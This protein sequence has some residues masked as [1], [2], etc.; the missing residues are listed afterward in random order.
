MYGV[1][2]RDVR[3]QQLNQ[4]L[5]QFTQADNI[6]NVSEKYYTIVKGT[7]LLPFLGLTGYALR[8]EYVEAPTRLVNSSDISSLPDD[9]VLSTVPYLATGEML[10]N[11]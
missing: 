11:R 3:N 1:D 4:Q 5:Y 8:F 6:S 9:Y 2:Y 7:Y 10:F